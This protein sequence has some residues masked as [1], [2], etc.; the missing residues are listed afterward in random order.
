MPIHISH[1]DH[2][3]LT[4]RDIA[5]TCQFYAVVLQQYCWSTSYERH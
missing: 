4:V 3:V 1:I 2:L 5:V